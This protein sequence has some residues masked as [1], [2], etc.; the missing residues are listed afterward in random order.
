V[1]DCT[2]FSV[3]DDLLDGLLD[4]LAAAAVVLLAFLLYRWKVVNS[5]L[6]GS[7]FVVVAELLDLLF[8]LVGGFGV[9]DVCTDLSVVDDLL[10]FF[11]DLLAVAVVLALLAFLLF[12]LLISA[13]SSSGI[14]S[15]EANSLLDGSSLAVVAELLDLLFLLFLLV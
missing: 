6:D 12:T 9:V 5:S 15:K 3:V 11:L 4:L 10:D 7:S 1:D 8:F 13:F 14:H 2:D